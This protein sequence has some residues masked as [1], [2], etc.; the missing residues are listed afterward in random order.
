VPDNVETGYVPVAGSK[1]YYERKGSGPA[2]V[3]IHS[4]F[5]DSRMW[6][7]QFDS[8]SAKYSVIRYDIRGHGRSPGGSTP[9]VD[10]EDA[11]ALLDH[12]G[13]ADAFVIG[14]SNGARTACGLAAGAPD[15]VRGLVLAGGVPVDLDPTAEEEARFMDSLPERDEKI[16]SLEKE[17]RIAEAVEVM[18]NAWAPDVVEPMRTYLQK[19]AT[20]NIATMIALRTGKLPSRQPSYPVAEALRHSPIPMLLVCGEQDHPALEMMMGRFSR[21]LPHVQFIKLPEA[22]HTANLS[23]GPAFDRLVLDFLAAT[24]A[25][26]VATT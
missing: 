7:P 26:G 25:R 23:A 19:I 22:D 24:P 5:L 9:Y 12:L 3:L 2:V 11:L 18:L 10:A 13:V 8:F 20:D 16:L 21:Q 14:I 15:R 4:G 6:D 1:L 17:G